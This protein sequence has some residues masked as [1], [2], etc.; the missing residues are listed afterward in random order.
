MDDFAYYSLD[1]ILADAEVRRRR[2]QLRLRR[3]PSAAPDARRRLPRDRAAMAPVLVVDQQ[4]GAAMW[5]NA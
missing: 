5:R 4:C 3:V 2:D 1:D